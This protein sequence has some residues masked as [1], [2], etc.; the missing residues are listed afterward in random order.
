MV[1]EGKILSH[2]LFQYIS[3][4]LELLTV[5]HPKDLRTVFTHTAIV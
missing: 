2:V 1:G 3:C 4:R 5:G